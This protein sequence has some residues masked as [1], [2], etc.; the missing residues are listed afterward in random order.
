MD[1]FNT[2]REKNKYFVCGIILIALFMS[3]ADSGDVDSGVDGLSWPIA[4]T[5][6]KDCTITN[7]VDLDSTV[8]VNDHYAWNG[9]STSYDG[10]N[11]TDIIPGATIQES[12]DKM[13]EGMAILAAADGVVVSA[14]DNHYDRCVAFPA[15]NG[16]TQGGGYN[17][18]CDDGSGGTDEI[19]S[20]APGYLGGTWTFS[21][22][23]VWVKHSGV[24]GVYRIWYGHLKTGSLRVSM[25]DTVKR[26][27][28]LAEVGSSGISSNPHLHFGVYNTSD[29][30]SDIDPYW[31]SASATAT[32]FAN[33]L[34]RSLWAADPEWTSSA[35]D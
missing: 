32:Q 34:G 26:G 35:M 8:G 30:T 29:S 10:H 22:N 5:P 19:D 11:G 24:T 2:L 18:Q 3:C 15:A 9:S 21:G 20:S 6:G 12:W 14:Y 27:Q 13:D 4:C 31:G 33:P 16:T 23:W 17:A 7:Y 25:G 28:K 1:L